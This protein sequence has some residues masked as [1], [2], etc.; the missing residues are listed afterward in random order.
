MIAT[1]Y[2]ALW[3]FVF[4]LPWENVFVIPGL[5]TIS[6]LMG[7]VAVAFAA[8]AALFTGRLRHLNRFHVAALVFL[9]LAGM[10]VFRS[11]YA[12]VAVIKFKTYVQLF[13]VLWIIWELAPDTRHQRGLLTAYVFGSYVGAL[14]TIIVRPSVAH[15]TTRFAAEGFDPNDLGMTLALAIPMAWYLGMTYRQPL[16]RLACRGY[17]LIG[18]VAIGLTGSRG[19]MIATMFALLIVPMTMTRLSPARKMAAIIL[20]LAVGAVSVAFIPES[21]FQRFSSTKEEVEAGTLNGRL[22]I[23]TAGVHAFVQR[24]LLGWGAGSFD[25]TIVPWFGRP[26]APH[27]SYLCILVE[28]GMVGFLVWLTMYLTVFTQI[29]KLPTMERRFA[30]VLLGTMAVAMLPL[31]WDDRKPVWFI[32]GVLVAFCVAMRNQQFTLGAVPQPLPTPVIPEAPAVRAA[33]RPVS[34]RARALPP[35]RYPR[36][37]RGPSG[38]DA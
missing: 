31:G 11:V 5:G 2:A 28:Q 23:W 14:L 13:A 21:S 34:I 19:A 12:D 32:A 25:R 17:L 18:V 26:R 30:L 24:P 36:K 22:Q 29:L 33:R 16:L 8:L 7:L 3:I 4:A 10:S 20:V 9:I 27:N 38:N 1:A 15:T 6:K 37:P 35:S